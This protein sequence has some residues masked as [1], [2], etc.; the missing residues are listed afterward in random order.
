[1]KKPH[2]LYVEDETK[3]AELIRDYLLAAD[4][5]VTV[6]HSGDGVIDFIRSNPPDLALLDLM[7]PVVD[8]LTLCRQIREFSE[9]PI[10]MITAKVEEIDRLLGLQIGA[11][12][13]VCKPAKPREVVARVKA[14]LR[15]VAMANSNE[16]SGR[17][18]LDEERH[19]VVLDGKKLEVTRIEFRLLSLLAKRPG[20]VYSR[21]QLM[22]AVHD[23][24]RDSSD[25]AIDSHIKNLRR[26]MADHSENSDLIQSVYGV[27][28]KLIFDE[29]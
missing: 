26:K 4:Y 9:L 16:T 6:M 28:Y 1:M 2:V 14:L 21:R 15:R 22:Q 23:D 27:G 10:I 24:G 7:L 17:L 20:W 29:A 18:Q 12:D 11:D 13:Y 25:R 19:V 5:D 8:G 3:L